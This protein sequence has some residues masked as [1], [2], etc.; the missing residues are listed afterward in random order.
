MH[1]DARGAQ[2]GC[3]RARLLAQLA[4]KLLAPLVGHPLPYVLAALDRVDA[5]VGHLW[6]RGKGGPLLWV[7]TCLGWALGLGKG[8]GQGCELRRHSRGFRLRVRVRARAR[9]RSGEV[10]LVVAHLE[11]V[12]AKLGLQLVLVQ[13]MGQD[14]GALEQH[15]VR[16]GVGKVRGRLGYGWGG[17]GLG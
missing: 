5:Q 14:G 8:L 17:L 16:G 6:V 3:R 12:R 1:A 10:H 7:I 2:A 9:V 11:D 4:E 13:Q 15:L